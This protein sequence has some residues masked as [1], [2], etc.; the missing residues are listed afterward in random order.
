MQVALEVV[1]GVV[2][3]L[4]GVE[5]VDQIYSSEG[6]KLLIITLSLVHAFSSITF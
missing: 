4:E 6:N 1:V 2:V 5:V 3:V